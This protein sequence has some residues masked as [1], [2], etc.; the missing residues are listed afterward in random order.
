MNAP[1]PFKPDRFRSA[2]AHYLE[3]RPDYAAALVPAVARL[4]RLDGA[5]QMLD[6]GCGPGQLATA[7]RPFVAGVL[8]MGP[9]TRDA[10]PRPHAR[11]GAGRGRD[12]PGRGVP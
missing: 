8:G 5:G 2:A 11:R 4:C 7:F 10:C 3:G 1:I 6:L 12:I 9:G